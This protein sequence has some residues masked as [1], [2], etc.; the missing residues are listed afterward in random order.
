MCDS[1]Q[2]KKKDKQAELSLNTVIDSL[3]QGT[4]SS[5]EVMSVAAIEIFRDVAES[6]PDLVV[7]WIKERWPGMFADSHL[8]TNYQQPPTLVVNYNG[9]VSVYHITS[10]DHGTVRVQSD[11]TSNY[12]VTI[13]PVLSHI[14]QTISKYPQY[15]KELHEHQKQITEAPTKAERLGRLEALRDW[16]DRNKAT[17][18]SSTGIMADIAQVIGTVA[19]I[20]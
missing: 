13:A 17:I 10:G 7:G 8:Q 4:S 19:A 20:V 5:G 15:T 12:I 6:N 3:V 9:P 18:K 11:D 16:F 14:D 2:I 1:N